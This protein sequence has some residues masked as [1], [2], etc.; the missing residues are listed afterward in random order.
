M[1]FLAPL[2]LRKLIR[3]KH[4]PKSFKKDE[5]PCLANQ[6]PE[7]FENLKPF[8][9]KMLLIASKIFKKVIPKLYCCGKIWPKTISP[10][11]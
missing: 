2:F 5:I 3:G 1:A 6:I 9:P 8:A 10:E 4:L 7:V 11:A